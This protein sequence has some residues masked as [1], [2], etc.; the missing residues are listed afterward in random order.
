MPTAGRSQCCSADR[1]GSTAL[2]AC[3]DPEDALALIR[4]YQGAVDQVVTR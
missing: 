3:L 4:A 1:V 2:A